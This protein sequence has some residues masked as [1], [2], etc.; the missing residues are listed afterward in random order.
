MTTFAIR[1]TGLNSLMKYLGMG[2]N[3]SGIDVGTD[4][5][6]RMGWAFSVRFR[7]E[8]IASVAL[9]AQRVY[10]WGVH[11][12]RGRWL[13]NGSSKG[14]VRIDLRD[15]VRGRLMGVPVKVSTIRVSMETPDDLVAA[16]S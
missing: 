1:Y 16:L 5:R 4:V 7:R 13:V 6:I 8:E 3:R 15:P 2:P 10:G 12:W 14:L 9:D 11:G